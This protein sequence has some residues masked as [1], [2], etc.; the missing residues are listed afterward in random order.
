LEQHGK[1]GGGGHLLAL[2]GTLPSALMNNGVEG[3]EA[4]GGWSMKVGVPPEAEAE[5]AM[6]SPTLGHL[7]TRLVHVSS[8]LESIATT[9]LSSTVTGVGLMG[10]G[11]GVAEVEGAMASRSTNFFFLS[12]L[13]PMSTHKQLVNTESRRQMRH[14]RKL[15]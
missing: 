3:E 2:R 13:K 12:S 5:G 4:L 14:Q 15:K 6:V 8:S 11:A 7:K 9:P 1:L 10:W